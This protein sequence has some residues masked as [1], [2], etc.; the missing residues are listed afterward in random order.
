MAAGRI[1]RSGLIGLG[2]ILVAGCSDYYG[3][4]PGAYGGNH[5]GYGGYDSYYGNAYGWRSVP[6]GYAGAGFGWYNGYYYPGN[7]HFAYDRG[8]RRF[9]L[10]AQHRAY[11]NERGRDRRD[12]RADR[13]GDRRDLRAGVV[14][15][16]QFRAERRDDRRDFRQDRRQDRR[17][18]GVGGNNRRGPG[19]VSGAIARPLARGQRPPR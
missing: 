16:P 3:A 18:D 2:L 9:T 17:D 4:G 11:W 19:S 13:R 12:F 1:F 5:A 10:P 7:G 8:G 14:T 6:Y 15:Q